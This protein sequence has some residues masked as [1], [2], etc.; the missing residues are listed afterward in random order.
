[1]Q[2]WSK[3]ESDLEFDACTRASV[4]DFDTVEHSPI[5][6]QY[7][8]NG[9]CD[10]FKIAKDTGRLFHRCVDSD[11]LTASQVLDRPFSQSDHSL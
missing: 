9:A 6:L 1:M 2:C 11:L 7:V 5:K 3:V 4:G 8:L 10:A